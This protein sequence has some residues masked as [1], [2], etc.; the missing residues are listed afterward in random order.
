MSAKALATET[1]NRQ[2]QKVA[3]FDVT[4]IDRS[5]EIDL[6]FF[7]HSFTRLC[8]LFRVPPLSEDEMQV[9]VDLFRAEKWTNARFENAC[10]EVIR[11]C[12]RFPTYA[13][14]W[15]HREF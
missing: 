13:D 6:N 3:V 14:F 4:K 1:S 8:A 7:I 2:S 12:T 15:R 9:W 10:F 11:N 5:A